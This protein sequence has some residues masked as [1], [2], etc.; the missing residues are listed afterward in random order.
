MFGRR[1][2]TGLLCL[3]IMTSH[4]LIAAEYVSPET[5]PGATTIDTAQA[6]S[7]FDR[8][9]IFIDVRSD[10]DWEAGRIPGAVHLELDKGYTEASLGAV[11][12]LDQEVV[13]YCNGIK[14]PR[15][16]M[17]AATAV[18]WGFTRVY[19]YRLGFPDWQASGYPVE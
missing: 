12:R 1:I 18:R 17:A 15:S 3:T 9:A 6:K 8:G 11:A 7:L 13:M 16:S 10:A 4:T 14:C 19:Y 2:A 5:V